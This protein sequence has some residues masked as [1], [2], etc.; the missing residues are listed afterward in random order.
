MYL[1][2]TPVFNFDL[3]FL[4]LLKGIVI[5]QDLKEHQSVNHS[6]TIFKDKKV[7]ISFQASG[8]LLLDYGL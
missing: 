6:T 4:N 5:R 3:V 2:L 8:E 7:F 1:I